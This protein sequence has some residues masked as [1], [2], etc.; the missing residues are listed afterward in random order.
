LEKYLDGIVHFAS[1]KHKEIS[2]DSGAA[3]LVSS[4]VANLPE[5]VELGP[6]ELRI[7]FT[8]SED[9]L[10]KFGAVVFALHNDLE[11]I[12]ELLDKPL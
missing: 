6:G 4:R 9:F 11:Q 5:G 7:R 3:A 1:R 8:D 2:R 10:Q 12:Q